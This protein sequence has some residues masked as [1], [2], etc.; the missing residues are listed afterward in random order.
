M[1]G[2]LRSSCCAAVAALSLSAVA[3]AQP[4]ASLLACP[5]PDKGVWSKELSPGIVMHAKR[6]SRGLPLEHVIYLGK[7]DVGASSRL[8]LDVDVGVDIDLDWRF[9]KSRVRGNAD[10]YITGTILVDGGADGTAERAYGINVPYSERES[11]FRDLAVPLLR[12][13]GTAPLERIYDSLG[14]RSGYVREVPL[15]PELQRRH[16]RSVAALQKQVSC[17]V[18]AGTGR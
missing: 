10:R 8:S 14:S 18:P 4:Y 15:T 1:N 13:A 12:D 17:R 9:W 5:V 3:A 11:I 7:A 16:R 6:I 2:T